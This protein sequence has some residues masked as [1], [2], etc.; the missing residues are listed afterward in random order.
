MPTTLIRRDS[1]SP[2]VKE[3]EAAQ[4]MIRPV[5]SASQTR[6]R[7]VEPEQRLGDVAGDRAHPAADRLAVEA[8]RV[9]HRV[10]PDL[11]RRIALGANQRVDGAAVIRLEQPGEHLP[12]EEARRPGDQ[13][14]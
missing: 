1:S 4:W 9:E 5:R 14:P 10:Q 7:R 12:A 11:R 8:E 2:S 3:T 6:L 13:D